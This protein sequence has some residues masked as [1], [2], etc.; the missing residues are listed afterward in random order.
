MRASECALGRVG[1]VAGMRLFLAT[2]PSS[3]AG[4]VAGTP[5]CTGPPNNMPLAPM[6]ALRTPRHPQ[7]AAHLPHQLAP[8]SKFSASGQ[9]AR[10]ADWG[11]ENTFPPAPGRLCCDAPPPLLF[12]PHPSR[13][14]PAVPFLPVRPRRLPRRHAAV[15]CPHRQHTGL[16]SSPTTDE[17]VVRAAVC[18]APSRRPAPAVAALRCARA[19]RSSAAPPCGPCER[20]GR[21]KATHRRHPNPR[22][23]RSGRKLL[24]AVG[25]GAAPAGAPGAK[26]R[27]ARAASTRHASCTAAL[28]PVPGAGSSPAAAS[29]VARPPAP[30]GCCCCC[31]PAVDVAGRGAAR[32][33]LCPWA[34]PPRSPSAW[35]HCRL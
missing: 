19:A 18:I 26:P 10:A 31:L 3:T 14:A 11:R 9:L 35:D 8:N 2:S 20:S 24:L 32:Q 22:H 15:S 16:R 21:L 13:H 28:A 33:T 27:P 34:H 1:G 12:P 6:L 30:L 7:Q 5:T 17:K 29:L 4:R 23:R 25:S